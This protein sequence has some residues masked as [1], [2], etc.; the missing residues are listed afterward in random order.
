MQHG[1]LRSSYNISEN[2]S[3]I[4]LQIKQLVWSII[5]DLELTYSNLSLCGEVQC[6]FE[7]SR[8]IQLLHENMK[9]RVIEMIPLDEWISSFEYMIYVLDRST[10]SRILTGQ[11]SIKIYPQIPYLPSF[12]T[13]TN[14]FDQCQ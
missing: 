1:H 10:D 7:W 4:T 8:A 12:I 11:G 14:L 2:F 3:L 5:K 13:Q 6:Y 9:L